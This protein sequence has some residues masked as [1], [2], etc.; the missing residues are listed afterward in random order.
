M[1]IDDPAVLWETIWTKYKDLVKEHGSNIRG[2]LAQIALKEYRTVKAYFLKIE[3]LCADLGVVQGTPV[4]EEEK[5]TAAMHG[6]PD[7]WNPVKTVIR[8]KVD[9]TYTDMKRQLKEYETDLQKALAI[10]ADAALLVNGAPTK[11]TISSTSAEFPSAVT[12]EVD[13][14]T[15]REETKRKRNEI[16]GM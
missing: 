14:V 15:G 10:P 9:Y 4:S 3:A 1:S 6:V 7:E 8:G 5:I 11:R 16:Q 2:Q 12:Q 13:M